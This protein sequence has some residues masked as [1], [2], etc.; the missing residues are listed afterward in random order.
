MNDIDKDVCL[1]GFGHWPNR[2]KLYSI[3]FIF[4]PVK[5]PYSA[6]AIFD[7]IEIIDIA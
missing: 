4:A 1:L 6:S 3:L 5:G 2:I 7:A